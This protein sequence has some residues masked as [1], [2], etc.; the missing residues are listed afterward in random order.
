MTRG[1][2]ATAL[3]ERSPRPSCGARFDVQREL[4]GEHDLRA[5][6]GLGKRQVVIRDGSGAGGELRE[7]AAKSGCE[8]RDART[9]HLFAGA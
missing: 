5:G 4:R 7:R 3:R 9:G 8:Q 1:C 2:A 6:G